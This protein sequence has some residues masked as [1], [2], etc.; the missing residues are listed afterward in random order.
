MDLSPLKDYLFIFSNTE[1]KDH[2]I[3]IYNNETFAKGFFEKISR[4]GTKYSVPPADG[5]PYAYPHYPLEKVFQ[6]PNVDEKFADYLR[7]TIAEE[8]TEGRLGNFGWYILKEINIDKWINLYQAKLA[9]QKRVLLETANKEEKVEQA[10]L[11]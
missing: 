1:L 4:T 5:I 3:I 9:E 8:K 6:V 7:N 10:K 2:Y 11:F